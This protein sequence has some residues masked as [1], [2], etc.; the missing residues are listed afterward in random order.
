[1]YQVSAAPQKK[2]NEEEDGGAMFELLPPVNLVTGT[3]KG[4]KGLVGSKTIAPF[5][6]L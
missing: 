1:M 4:R 5:H 2:I 3:K 6:Y